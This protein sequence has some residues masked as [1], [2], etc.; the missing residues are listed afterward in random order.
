DVERPI[1]DVDVC[2]EREVAPRRKELEKNGD[3]T[4]VDGA[5]RRPSR[6]DVESI[7]ARIGAPSNREEFGQRVNH[8]TPHGERSVPHAAVLPDRGAAQPERHP[9]GHGAGAELAM[10]SKVQAM[11]LRLED[12][13]RH[14]P[15]LLPGEVVR[16]KREAGES[17][18]P[19]EI[20]SDAR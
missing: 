10:E 13:L 5:E 1:P 14:A 20:V 16:T 3:L 6:L 19:A 9:D 12:G 18:V 7:E 2:S 8:P 17:L 11:E 4:L 15:L